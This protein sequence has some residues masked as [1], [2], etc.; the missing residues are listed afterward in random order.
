MSATDQLVAN[1]TAF[2][3]YFD[4]GHLKASPTS[5]LAVLMCMDSR[6]DTFKAFGLKAGEA[7][8][9]RNAGG[10]ATDDAIRSL[11]LSQRVLGTQEI[12]LIHHT[13][14]GLL[15]ASEYDL[16][17]Q[18]HAETGVRPAF[19]LEAFTDVEEDVRRTARRIRATP[20]LRHDRMRGFVYQVETGK[21]AEIELY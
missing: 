20:F 3:G 18:I 1:N 7:H 16:Y 21:A 17:Q 13:D 2:A 6:I 12:V 15:G 5:H 11:M 19:P 8:I 9:I 10:V 4:L 14:C